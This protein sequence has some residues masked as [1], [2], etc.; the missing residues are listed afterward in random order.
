MGHRLAT[1]SKV[2]IMKFFVSPYHKYHRRFNSIKSDFKFHIKFLIRTLFLMTFFQKG[3]RIFS[4][5]PTF[6]LLS[7]PFLL[8]LPPRLSSLLPP[9]I[10][11]VPVFTTVLMVM[12][13][14]LLAMLLLTLMPL[15]AQLPTVL[16]PDLPTALPSLPS[17][18]VPWPRC[19]CP[20]SCCHRPNCRSSVCCCLYPSSRRRPSCLCCC[21]S[22]LCSLCRCPSCLCRCPCCLCRCPCCLCRCS[23]CCS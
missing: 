3:Q 17:M 15:L 4:L 14:G 5:K 12:V 16:M 19:C 10:W 21:P 11:E 22:C 1:H 18:L 13:L 7:L 23:Y 6:R 8:L 20:C 2:V 9:N